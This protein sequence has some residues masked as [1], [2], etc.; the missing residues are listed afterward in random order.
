M[1][2]ETDP[3]VYDL[4][5]RWGVQWPRIKRHERFVTS[6]SAAR[7][8][9]SQ[10]ENYAPDGYAFCFDTTALKELAKS[11]KYS[12]QPCIYDEFESVCAAL[13]GDAFHA[14]HFARQQGMDHEEAAMCAK[15]MFE[16]PIST[17]S[18]HLKRKEFAAEAEYRLLTLL[19][20]QYGS[21]RTVFR[22]P[23]NAG[24]ISYECVSFR[25]NAGGCALREIMVAPAVDFD[26]ARAELEGVL[27]RYGYSDVA[28]VRSKSE[29]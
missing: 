16:I 24:L 5:G 27:Q 6:L 1:A 11:Q 21:T 3:Y 22:R 14:Y 13:I 29:P 23:G 2:V 12:L 15:M 9:A 4:I 26:S 25:G 18:A 10:W 8:L 20:V 7:D 17:I 28:I 19:P